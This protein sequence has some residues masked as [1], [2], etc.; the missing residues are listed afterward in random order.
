[1]S[2]AHEVLSPENGGATAVSCDGLLADPADRRSVP[3]YAVSSM[4]AAAMR[5]TS[6]CTPA[7]RWHVRSIASHTTLFVISLRCLLVRSRFCV[8]NSGRRNQDLIGIKIK[9]LLIK[10]HVVCYYV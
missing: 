8:A 7:L 5:T 10:A 9:L 2:P 1:M 3:H 4:S 6:V